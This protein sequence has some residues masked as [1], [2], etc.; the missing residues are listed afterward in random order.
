MSFA[1][2]GK[3]ALA[4]QRWT[5]KTP[6]L[7]DPMASATTSPI[8]TASVST[9]DGEWDH[10]VEI[11]VTVHLANKHRRVHVSDF[12]AATRAAKAVVENM[13]NDKATPY[14]VKGTEANVR[15]VYVGYER[16]V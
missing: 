11:T 13:L 4:G 5:S 6:H 8:T 16:T 1:V 3:S 15:Y 7:E 2:A 12:N 14:E 9:D 10:D